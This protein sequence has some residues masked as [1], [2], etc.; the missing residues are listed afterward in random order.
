MQLFHKTK[1]E[2]TESILSEGFRDGEGYYLTD[3]VWRG[4]WQ[5]DKPVDPSRDGD[6]TLFTIDIPED[7][8]LEFEW[9]EE[10]KPIREFLVPATLVNSYG[11]PEITEE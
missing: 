1:R 6:D 3:E 10:G 7:V 5:S 4:V 11:P 8:I 2:N 9:V